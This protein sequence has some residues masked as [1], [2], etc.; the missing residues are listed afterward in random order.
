MRVSLAAVLFLVVVA[1]AA[2]EGKWTKSAWYRL[3]I[4]P[5]LK[6]LSAPFANEKACKKMLP[7]G[8]DDVVTCAH[9]AKA[10]DEVDRAIEF[11]TAEIAKNPHDAAAMMCRGN[12]YER[13]GENDAAL[14]EYTNAMKAN[15]DDYT[16]LIMRAKLYQKLE[17]RDEAVADYRAA[18][19]RNPGRSDTLEMIHDALKALGADA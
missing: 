9:L 2:A 10:G 18:L 5:D 17:K 8:H 15:P 6:I 13:K 11:F 14:I 12:L 16:A 4:F 7:A 3:E 1:T 19:A